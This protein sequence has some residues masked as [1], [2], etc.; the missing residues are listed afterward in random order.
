MSERKRKKKEKDRRL[1]R[2]LAPVPQGP[3]RRV[4]CLFLFY[5]FLK[6]K[7]MTNLR[8]V[9]WHTGTSNYYVITCLPLICRDRCSPI[10]NVDWFLG[11]EIY[12]FYSYFYVVENVRKFILYPSIV[13]ILRVKKGERWEEKKKKKDVPCIRTAWLRIYG[14]SSSCY[15]KGGKRSCRLPDWCGAKDMPV[16]SSRYPTSI[17]AKAKEMLYYTVI[18][19]N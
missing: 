16:T 5:F 10:Y 13:L 6:R 18:I 17:K 4:S 11:L 2:A 3:L 14:R 15:S 12:M 19:I 8:Q 1:A 9:R 7:K